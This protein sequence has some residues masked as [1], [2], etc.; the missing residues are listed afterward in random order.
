MSVKCQT[1]I[2]F[3]EDFAPQALALEGD[4]IGWQVGDPS[5][6]IDA[7]L[8]AM[9]VD[10]EIVKEAKLLSAGLII[11][12]HPLIFKPLST[13]RLDLPNGALIAKLL[14][15]NIGVYSAHTNL[16]IAE[17]GVNAVLAHK[18]DLRDTHMLGTGP[19][20]LGRI[21]KLS[22]PRSLAEVA[23]GIKRVLDVPYL[24]VGGPLQ[25]QIK[26]VAVCG[27]SGADYWKQALAS[28]ADVYVTGDLKY[29]VAREML[30]AGLSFIDPGH[31]ASER[32][33]LEPLRDYLVQRFNEA[34][35]EVECYVSTTNQDPFNQQ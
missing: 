10:Q 16:D 31:Y 11:V 33:I 7:V 9:D 17:Q 6:E 15:K 13:I 19:T 20:N 2:S 25:G 18:L 32:I 34:H 28:G 4:N 12:H 26:K 3:L 8:L 29:H 1:V 30:A 5:A 24:R 21:G 35:M 14:R 23:A 22:E 27:G